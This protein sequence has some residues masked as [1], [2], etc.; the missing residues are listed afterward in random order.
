MFRD[1]LLWGLVVDV[2]HF[3]VVGFLYMNP[4]LAGEYKKADAG[5]ARVSGA[6][7]G[8]FVLIGLPALWFG[9]KQKSGV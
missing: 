6:I 8:F 2:I 4:L 3:I 1:I 5:W 7:P 9:K